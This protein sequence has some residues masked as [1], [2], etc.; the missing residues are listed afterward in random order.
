MGEIVIRYPA[1]ID[2]LDEAIW[3]SGELQEK[4]AYETHVKPGTL[5]KYK[6]GKL[7]IPLEFLLSVFKT[8]VGR[9]KPFM[10]FM[11][12]LAKQNRMLRKD[13]CTAC[14]GCMSNRLQVV[15]MMQQA[16]DELATSEAA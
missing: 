12:G 7:P 3:A 15:N 16:M 10:S 5:S 6:T 4:L 1:D 2:F 9:S 8:K 14:G 11:C 13:I